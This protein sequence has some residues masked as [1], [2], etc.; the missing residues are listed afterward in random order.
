MQYDINAPWNTLDEWQ[1][2]YIE[3]EAGQNCFLLTGRQC[4]KTTAMS[5]KAVE[6]CMRAFKKGE[7][8]LIASI[9]ERQG[10]HLLAKSLAYA[11][12]R[13]GKE[14]KK[15]KDKPTKHKIEFKNGAGILS[16]PAGESGEGLRGFTIK[17]LMIDEGSRMSE[18]F[19][20]A[21]TPQLSII[22][23][24]IDIASTP[25]G[26]KGFFY[27]CSMDENFKKYY[28]SA[29]K[30][31]RHTQ[32][33]L[34]TEKKR[35][36]KLAYAQEYLAIFTD[37]LKRLFSDE[38]INK[39]C[40][41]K[42]M[43]VKT[44]TE[45]NYIGVD[46]A[47]LGKDE[48]TYEVVGKNKDNKIY[49]LENIIEEKTYTTDIVRRIIFLE[50][51]YN[52]KTI[53]IDDGGIGFGVFSGLL[54][55]DSTKRKTIALNNASRKTNSEGDK[56]KKLLKEE[57]YL[58]L[59]ALMENDMIEL[60]QDDALIESLKSIQYETV[61]GSNKETKSHIFGSYTHIAEGLIRAVWCASEDKTLNIIAYSF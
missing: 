28:I 2:D 14:I 24:T 55:N 3:T 34:D 52:T 11:Q 54:E 43:D 47:G 13:Y 22:G 36:S 25:C 21:V 56:S 6:L 59:L 61:T 44:N 50:K 38:I 4:G 12:A 42:K 37:E 31:P 5:I 8:V 49:H 35:L 46:V 26:K 20:I 9:T 16:Y 30:C 7:F 57:M 53:G 10:Y 33:Y 45:K 1:K 27:Q 17:K 51:K 60:L 19:F 58:R 48:T 23:G 29:E 18:E 15:G 32:E 41:V 40:C 39:V